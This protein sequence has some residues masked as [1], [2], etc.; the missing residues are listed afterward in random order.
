MVTDWNSAVETAQDMLRDIGLSIYRLEYY[1]KFSIPFGALS[2]ILVAVSI[3]LMANKSGQTVGF[4]MGITIAAVYWA[5]LLI[6]QDLGTRL[7]FSPFWSM[8]FPNVLA[9]VSGLG[10]TAIRIS[11][12]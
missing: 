11:T 10:L 2:F 7:G 8:W 1:K 3:G 5:L 6:G 4:I 12:R 9:I